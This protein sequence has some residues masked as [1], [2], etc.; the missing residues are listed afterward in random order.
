MRDIKG[1]SLVMMGASG[2][3][4]SATAVRLARE[5]I[6]I[7]ICSIDEAGLATLEKELTAKGA[8]V[9]SKVVDVVNEAEVA[10]FIDESAKEFGTLDVLFNFAGLSVTATAENLSE[11]D[12]DTVMDVNVKGMVMATKHF[13]GKVD[14]EKGAQIINFG[15][16]AAIRANPNAPHYSAAKAAVN[17][18]S[19]GLA[20]QLKSRNIK[21]TIFN[22]GPTDTTFF[23]GRIPKEKRTK[24]MQ[25]D[26]VAQVIEFLL[27]REARLVFH[28]LRFESFEFF[29]G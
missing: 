14:E 13:I 10:A 19:E 3:I 16:M 26:D 9:F 17:L 4:G 8:Q 23:E 5:G 20:Q 24:F 6:K 12:Y 21:V 1:M 27:T 28:E 22:P 11:A 18:Y 7:A 25:A 2:G 15:S 29:K